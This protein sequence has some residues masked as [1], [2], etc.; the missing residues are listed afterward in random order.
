MFG[1]FGIAFHCLYAGDYDRAVDHL[2]EGFEISD[3]NLPYIGSPT[4]DPLRSNLRFTELLR[5]MN[6]PE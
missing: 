2:E 3:P 6:L 5:R 1:N 4:F